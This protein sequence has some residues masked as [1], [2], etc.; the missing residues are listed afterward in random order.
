MCAPNIYSSFESSDVVFIGKVDTVIHNGFA[1]TIGIADYTNFIVYKSYKGCYDNSY[2]RYV[3]VFNDNGDCKYYFMQ[4]SLYLV[5]AKKADVFLS[6]HGCMSNE[7]VN[8]ITKYEKVFKTEHVFDVNSEGVSL[9][10]SR[11]RKNSKE[12]LKNINPK[13]YNKHFSD[14]TDTIESDP[15]KSKNVL[16]FIISMILFLSAFIFFAKKNF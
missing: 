7:K 5:F 10:R 9:D 3:S 12:Y 15:D 8:D 4:D 14:N 13:V 2:M 16:M 1:T 6:T 11:V